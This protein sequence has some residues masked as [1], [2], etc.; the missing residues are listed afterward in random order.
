M[1]GGLVGRA[2]RQ[3]EAV[4]CVP[5]CVRASAGPSRDTRGVLFASFV[6]A[7]RP[8]HGRL[9]GEG[10]QTKGGGVCVRVGASHCSQAQM[11]AAKLIVSMQ[12]RAPMQPMYSL[13]YTVYSLPNVVLPF[14]GGLFV[15]R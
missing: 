4:A 7:V 10:A 8:S 6:C 14:F 3:S 2:P 9:R 13:F 1:V 12:T 11:A 5:A 15:D